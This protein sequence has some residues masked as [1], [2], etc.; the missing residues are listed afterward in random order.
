MIIR[1]SQKF[2]EKL[3]EAGIKPASGWSGQMWGCMIICSVITVRMGSSW[4]THA[5]QTYHVSIH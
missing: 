2:A 3:H 4:R 1:L 5:L